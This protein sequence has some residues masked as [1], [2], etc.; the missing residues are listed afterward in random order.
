M[1]DI[2]IVASCTAIWPDWQ[3]CLA[4]CEICIKLYLPNQVGCREMIEDMHRARRQRQV[5]MVFRPRRSHGG[6]RREAGRKPST[7]R[8]GV[9]R[10]GVPHRRRAGHTAVV[11]VH[12]T[13]RISD[14]A[15]A[16]VR[17][18]RRRDCYGVLRNAFV[19]GCR[20][21]GHHGRFRI[22][23]YSVQRTHI[24]MI[25]EAGS[26]AALSRGMQGFSIRVAK[27]I[28]RL[29]GR[30]G[31]VFGDRYHERPLG[32]PRQVR[33]GLAYV[34]NNA[35]HHGEHRG[36]PVGVQ[37]CWMDPFSSARYFDGWRDGRHGFYGTSP[38]AGQPRPVVA[39]ETWL[40]VHGWRRH[41][42]IAVDEEPGRA[43]R[44][45]GIRPEREAGRTRSRRAGRSRGGYTV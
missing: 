1:L 21:D 4:V 5:E 30:R 26:R 24:H 35:R 15:L 27:G 2:R 8:G 6:R 18:L 19:H 14:A 3:S 23:H 20:K 29:L 43:S 9:I 45:G 37:R 31:S 22:C 10:A 36:M 41:G 17:T 25:V 7:V 11:P 40:L 39:G 33:N 42:P 32:S 28:N 34:L 16:R 12:I 13:L 38:P 44:R